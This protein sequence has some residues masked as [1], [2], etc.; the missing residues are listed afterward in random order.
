M[1]K[2]NLGKGLIISC[3]FAL[4]G[5]SELQVS[6]KLSEEFNSSFSGLQECRVSQVQIKPYAES[7]LFF[8]FYKYEASEAR[9]IV[10]HDD[11]SADGNIL[12]IE[13]DM[14][15]Q[16]IKQVKDIEIKRNESIQHNSWVIKIPS[17]MEWELPYDTVKKV[18]WEAA[19]E[20]TKMCAINSKWNEGD[21][22]EE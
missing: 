21:S 16:R 2:D 6:D 17:K 19:K 10:G 4:A 8:P 15:F 5:C 11:D 14:P 12:A 3:F 13:L 18:I 9:V 1:K 22:Q 7:F 20:V